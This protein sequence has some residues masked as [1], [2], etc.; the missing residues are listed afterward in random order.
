MA[1]SVQLDHYHSKMNKRDFQN[2]IKRMPSLPSFTVDTPP[3]EHAQRVCQTL[4]SIKPIYRR[5]NYFSFWLHNV[6]VNTP[7]YHIDQI[8]DSVFGGQPNSPRLIQ[9]RNH[10]TTHLSDSFSEQQLL[11]MTGFDDTLNTKEILEGT[12]IIL[13]ELYSILSKDRVMSVVTG[14]WTNVKIVGDQILE[15]E[16]HTIGVSMQ[17]G[18]QHAIRD[19]FMKKEPRAVQTYHFGAEIIEQNYEQL[20]LQIANDN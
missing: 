9:P 10:S 8:D 16:V 3:L 5:S 6:L 15:V 14:K 17:H 20:A 4:Q 2:F 13:R 18:I 1:N 19:F 7:F 12:R 11:Y